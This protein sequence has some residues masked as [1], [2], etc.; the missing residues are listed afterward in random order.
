MVFERVC[1]RQEESARIPM[2][3]VVLENYEACVA[4]LRQKGTL[5]ANWGSSFIH[6][7]SMNNINFCGGRMLAIGYRLCCL[8]MLFGTGR[9]ALGCLAQHSVPTNFSYFAHRPASTSV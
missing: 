4:G 8:G 9:V 5:L 6:C 1:L 7:Y 2:G 3:K